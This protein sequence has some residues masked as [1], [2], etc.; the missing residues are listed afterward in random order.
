M[1]V[2][3]SYLL[4][5]E[6]KILYLTL[7]LS[8][9]LI[10]YYNISAGYSISSDSKR[11][12]MWADQLIE[13]NFN[14]YNFFLIEKSVLRP[15]LLLFSVPVFFIALCKIFFVNF[16]Q[17][18]F[19][20]F[21]LILIFISLIIF[22]KSLKLVGVRPI[23]ITLG[24]PLIVV[25][26]DVLTWPRFVLTDTIYAFV[27]LVAIF[28]I[29]KGIVN[30]KIYFLQ[31]ILVMIT[32]FITRPS[33]FSINFSIIFF[34]IILNFHSFF[35][36]KSIVFFFL[37]LLFS[38]PILFAIFYSIIEL[39]FNEIAKIEFITSMVKVGMIVHDRPDT[40]VDQPK[41]FF[42]IVYI[43]F[44][45]LIYFFNP[46]ASTFSTLHIILNIIQTAVIIISIFL[47]FYVGKKIINI[48]KVIVYILLLSF[49]VAAFHSFI[50]IDYDWRYRFPIILPLIMLFPITL[51]LL[52]RTKS[53]MISK[54]T[55]IN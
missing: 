22:V 44:L 1:N 38:T 36:I 48:N 6:N 51:E 54:L 33:S 50:L 11:L 8:F 53:K 20:L 24:L 43:Y 30:N 45:R 31:L 34:M 26:A 35:K 23:L 3:F 10:C 32:L 40:W 39:K 29:F 18:A 4:K 17:F 42:D 14:F 41:N 25:S 49:S 2:F 19:L 46:Y 12:S 15:H 27:V 21:N 7:I 37:A 13:L 5:N 28:Y 47:W 16:W 55:N 9:L 52:F